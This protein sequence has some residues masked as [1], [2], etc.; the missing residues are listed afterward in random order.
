[1]GVLPLQ[2]RDGESAASLNLNG[3][4]VYALSGVAGPD[5]TPSGTV[6]VAATREDGS[7][8]EFDVLARLDTAVEVE[9]YRHGGI[10]PYVLRALAKKT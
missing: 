8:I 2:F 9:Y 7:A 1:M 6:R 3:R 10:L 4:E 5:V